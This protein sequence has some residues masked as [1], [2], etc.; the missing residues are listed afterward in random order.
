[1]IRFLNINK[2]NAHN[3]DSYYHN[4]DDDDKNEVAVK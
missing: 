3:G 2:Y 1:M 4:D